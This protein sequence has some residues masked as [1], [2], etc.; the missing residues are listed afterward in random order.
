[1]V[2]R[3]M[4]AFLLT[5]TLLATA[6]MATAEAEEWTCIYD[7]TSN[8]MNFCK[9]CGRSMED[10]TTW[11][12]HACGNRNKATANFCTQCGSAK[13]LDEPQEAP[14]VPEEPEVPEVPDVPEQQEPEV[15]IPP[16]EILTVDITSDGAIITWTGGTEPYTIVAG[17]RKE[18]G[19][20]AV[21]DR[22][23]LMASTTC[24]FYQ[25]APGVSYGFEVTDVNGT[26]A[27][28]DFTVPEAASFVDGALMGDAFTLSTEKWRQ[29]TG[30]EAASARFVATE[31][32]GQQAAYGVDVKVGYPQ[33]ARTRTYET[34]A[35]VKAPNGYVH[36]I[37]CG[38]QEYRRVDGRGTKTVTVDLSNFFMGLNEAY[39]SVQ[40]GEYRVT[41]YLDGMY[42]ADGAFSVE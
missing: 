12:C 16:V 11:L 37:D 6:G 27:S 33:L 24:T 25:M 10:A 20:L 5:M 3:R 14:E 34:L 21:V 42:V 13:S 17:T 22:G 28:T 7:E 41:V 26:T 18:D 4:A 32:A 38:T 36:V 8:T 9:Q 39:G 15:Q 31:I 2:L 29:E 40:T 30:R 23:E 35:A 19:T 1:M